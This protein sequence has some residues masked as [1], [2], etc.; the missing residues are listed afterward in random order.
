MCKYPVSNTSTSSNAAHS[1]SSDGSSA[2]FKAVD[3]WGSFLPFAFSFLSL[4]LNW[5]LCHLRRGD[6]AGEG[7]ASSRPPSDGRMSGCPVVSMVDDPMTA[8][9][10]ELPRCIWPL[11]TRTSCPRRPGRSRALPLGAW[12][13]CPRPLRHFHL[14]A[15]EAAGGVGRSPTVREVFLALDRIDALV[16]RAALVQIGFPADDW[17]PVLE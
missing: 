5:R 8:R 13:S 2:Y 10:W 4:M 12:A 6:G 7:R 15:E 11:G 17:H 16:L 1:G 3:G 14:Y 9:C